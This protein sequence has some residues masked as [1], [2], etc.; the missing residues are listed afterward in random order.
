M[1]T[2]NHPN[3]SRQSIR[4]HGFGIVEVLVSI[5]LGL[6]IILVMMQVFARTEQWNRNASVGSDAQTNAQM[7]VYTVSRAISGAGGSL[8]A[9]RCRNAPELS[10]Y[11]RVWISGSTT[12][13][14]YL[15]MLPVVISDNG[16]GG[17]KIE[18]LAQTGVAGYGSQ[19][20]WKAVTAASNPLAV[21]S[22][23][24][25]EN[26]GWMLVSKAD[27]R[28]ASD[29]SFDNGAGVRYNCAL[30]PINNIT[31]ANLI[32][33]VSHDPLPAAMLPLGND[34]ATSGNSPSAHW[35]QG[36]GLL[37]FHRLAVKSPDS[38][39]PLALIRASSGLSDGVFTETI[40]APDV[41]YLKAF[42]GFDN[43]ETPTGKVTDWLPADSCSTDATGWIC[44]GNGETIFNNAKARTAERMIALRFGLVLRVPQHDKELKDDSEKP[45]A[46]AP[47]TSLTLW[48][49]DD[50]A[51]GTHNP[52]GSVSYSTAGDDGEYRYRILQTVIPLR[53][54]I[55]NVNKPKSE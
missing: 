36:A 27:S 11:D 29:E 44:S 55:W 35:V 48:N 18:F 24:G 33:D 51:P 3:P 34:L 4:T 8:I 20:L 6:I 41:V 25:V 28:E 7:A 53:S 52:G 45:G 23:Q 42:Y 49:W 13:R 1:N 38:G 17:D 26:G 21:R 47:P 5:T 39:G 31:N 50:V 19:R 32:Y 16:T 37:A 14:F 10:G 30:V 15:P 22:F 54:S 2:Q 9:A 46:V 40:E 12:D 43:E